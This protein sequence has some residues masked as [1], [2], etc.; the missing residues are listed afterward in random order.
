[1]SNTGVT[2]FP[3]G[4]YDAIPQVPLNTINPGV[5]STIVN[6]TQETNSQN[7]IE[8]F[9][10]NFTYTGGSYQG[11]VFVTNSS[12]LANANNFQMS[13][14]GVASS[15]DY[16]YTFFTQG[17]WS[18]TYSTPTYLNEISVKDCGE[19]WGTSESSTM[20]YNPANCPLSTP[21]QCT[22]SYSYGLETSSISAA[23]TNPS[24]GE[25]VSLYASIPYTVF[26][27]TASLKIIDL[28][29]GQTIQTCTGT[30]TS[31]CSAGVSY[32]S[33]TTQDYYSELLGPTGYVI[34]SS[35]PVAVT[36][37]NPP[38]SLTITSKNQYGQTIT[39]YYTE[40][41]QNGVKIGNGFTPYTFNN[42]VA[43]EQ[44]TVFVDNY[45]NCVFSQWS[46]GTT[47]RKDTF[48]MTSSSMALTA[49]YNCGSTSGSLTVDTV[50]QND[51]AINGYYVGIYDTSHNPLYHGYSPVT[52]NQLTVGT[53]YYVE[54]DSYGSCTFN[55][56]QDTGST[57]RDRLFTAQ[58]S[59]TLTA[60]YQ[61]T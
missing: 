58:S 24:L 51:Q 15:G 54:P 18:I 61:C 28:T 29:T 55:H 53:N 25:Q 7:Q 30:T 6:F 19:G 59:E 3:Q 16:G 26:D 56:W 9:I 45:G 37:G 34:A 35:A 57:V 5:S 36:W 8:D 52:F 42:L 14:D 13:I 4:S 31:S 12:Y 23:P 32:N 39:G 47:N 10:M 33:A 17:A 2:F 60:V 43:G 50:N 1:M 40:L 27:V 41:D 46:D 38:P 48:T 22:Q 11:Q 21:N 49:Y 44:Y 20:V